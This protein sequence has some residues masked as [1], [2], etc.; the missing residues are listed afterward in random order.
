MRRSLFYFPS[1]ETPNTSY[2]LIASLVVATFIANVLAPTIQYT[3]AAS[4]LYYVNATG[5][6][7]VND[8]LSSATA[9][10]TLGHVNAQ[11]FSQ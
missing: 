1:M 4:T 7:D 6:S 5:G 9:W 3:F 2:R 10:K 11:V 8:G